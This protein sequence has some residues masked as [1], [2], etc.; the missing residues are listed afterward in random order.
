MSK[1][2]CKRA[3]KEQ[4]DYI[5]RVFRTKPRVLIEN[6]G[7]GIELIE[8]LKHEIHGVLKITRAKEGD[9]MLRA[10]AASAALES[11]NCW[12]PGY[13]E[14]QDELSMPDDARNAAEVTDFIN[15]CAN[16]PNARYDDDVDA[17][18]QAMNWLSGRPVRTSRTFSSFRR[19]AAA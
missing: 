13:R 2:Q 9:K 16:F 6:A 12:L 7:Y 5:C 18:S 3:I 11:G 15:S 4:N 1:G 10:E 8:E 17:W 14:G 19:K